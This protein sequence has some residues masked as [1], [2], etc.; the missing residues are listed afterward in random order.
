MEAFSYANA[1]MIHACM[2]RLHQGCVL[3]SGFAQAKKRITLRD[4]LHHV[5]RD[6]SASCATALYDLSIFWRETDL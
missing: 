6:K 5:T 4:P 1:W 2:S 3:L